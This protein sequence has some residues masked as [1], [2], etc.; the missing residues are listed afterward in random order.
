MKHQLLRLGYYSNR[1]HLLSW[2]RI[3][4][5]A[6]SPKICIVGSG[7][8]SFYAAQHLIKTLPQSEVDIYEQL[9]VPFGLVRFGV[10]PDHPEV[11]NVI[12]TFTK[13][14]S[15]PNLRFVGNVSLGQD[16]TLQ[17]LKNAYHAVLLAY[18]ADEDREF[19]LEGESLGNVL[20]ARRFV[21]WYNGLPRDK[22]FSVNL[23]VEEVVILGQGNVALDVARI[24]LTPIDKLKSTDITAH[25]LDAL[26]RSRVRCVRLIGRRGP[27]QV[28]FT[29]KELRE[30]LKLPGCVTVCNQQDFESVRS[31][32]PELERPRRRLTELLCTAAESSPSGPVDENLKQFHLMFYRSPLSFHPSS[33]APHMVGSVKLG[34]NQLDHKQQAVPTGTTETVPCGLILRSIGYRST[35]A[36]PDVP[37]DSGR[38][39]VLNTK[40]VVQPGLYTAGWLAT[41]PMGVILSTMSQ[42]FGV[43]K[44]IETDLRSGRVD[45]SQT[46]PG[47]AAV[48]KLLQDRG[49]TTVS[50]SDWERIDAVERNR[51][52]LVGKPREKIVDVQE[53]LAV[54]IGAGGT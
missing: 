12:N 36:D 50:W 22:N 16:V 41:G 26:S 5:V 1:H 33:G 51:G 34:V 47:Y 54:S 52:E 28:A 48:S 8:A 23:D 14:A 6:S 38:G 49:V 21:G 29:I 37:F 15:S 10:A 39:H 13:T 31:V 43:G 3:S 25:A 42:A 24:L 20:S 46:K 32:I 4:S 7:P 44:A 11:K 35:Q 45:M 53:M 30:M 40:G 27:L 17:E 9:P 19:G 2:R 18:G